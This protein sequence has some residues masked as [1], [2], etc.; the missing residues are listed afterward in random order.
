MR[1]DL[2]LAGK[3][4]LLSFGQDKEKQ[5]PSTAGEQVEA[6]RVGK[7]NQT[8]GKHTEGRGKLPG[9]GGE[10]NFKIKQEVEK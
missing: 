4:L 8:G 7:D 6:I 10:L 3:R 9:T 2:D 5:P 1:K